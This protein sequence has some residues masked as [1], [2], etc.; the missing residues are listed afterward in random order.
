[1]TCCPA[2][3]AC[4]SALWEELAYEFA[5]KF[6]IELTVLEID[7]AIYQMIARPQDFD[8][9]V[10]P[11]MFGDVL[12]DSGALLLGSRGMSYSGNFGRDGRAVYQTGHGAAH[13]IAGRVL[14]ASE[15]WTRFD[16]S[17]TAWCVPRSQA[18]PA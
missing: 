9:I 17:S 7:N 12:A 18:G 10:S 4:G 13:D 16:A 5:P 1:L 11:N 15:F 8:V 3:S 6:G 14:S 2:A